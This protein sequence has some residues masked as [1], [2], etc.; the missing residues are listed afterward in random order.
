MHYCFFPTEHAPHELDKE[1]PI[2][3]DTEFIRGATYYPT[4]AL[5]QMH[6]LDCAE[7]WLCDPLAGPQNYWSLL[8]EHPAGICAHACLQDLE[9]MLQSVQRLPKRLFDTQYSFALLHEQISISYADLVH[10]YL[11]VVLP[12]DN[13]RSDWLERPLSRDQQQY[14]ADD[15]WYLAQLYP[16][17]C[18]HL[19]T[20]GRLSWALEDN[21]RFLN[22][23][24]TFNDDFHWYQLWSANRLRGKEILV[25]DVLCQWREAVARQLNVQR[26]K[27]LSDKVIL[28]LARA[29]ALRPHDYHFLSECEEL[30]PFLNDLYESLEDLPPCAPSRP[31]GSPLSAAERSLLEQLL[32]R[33]QDLAKMWRIHPNRIVTQ[34]EIRHLLSCH[35][36]KEIVQH[37]L[38]QGWRAEYF[39]D[40]LPPAA[41][42]Y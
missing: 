22:R 31:R 14:A 25:A 19:A 37:P 13:Q 15:V 11:G 36:Q 27:V 4:L 38:Y 35:F 20:Q 33:T 2:A 28:K 30:S 18:E 34:K 41:Q 39:A 21:E 23:M 1:Q 26:R 8:T 7:A 10:D 29:Q 12:K 5:V 3:F 16:R 40:L 32:Q 17:L 24:R 6:H 9:M 42:L